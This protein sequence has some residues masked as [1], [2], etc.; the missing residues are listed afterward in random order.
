M[1]YTDVGYAC[2]YTTLLS[3]LVQCLFQLQ[4]NRY[5]YFYVINTMQYF[6]Y[7]TTHVSTMQYCFIQ[8]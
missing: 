2:L 4:A 3:L 5:N 1:K 7:L 6:H 8:Y